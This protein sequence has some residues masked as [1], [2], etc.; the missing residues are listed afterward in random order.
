MFQWASRC[1]PGFSIIALLWL[2]FA[3]FADIGYFLPSQDQ[4][5]GRRPT[6]QPGRHSGDRPD[7][8]S[9]AQN[10]FIWFSVFVHLNAFY[11][12]LR[13]FFALVKTLRE[14]KKALQRRSQVKS[15]LSGDA[16][17]YLE[18]GSQPGL[19]LDVLDA[20]LTESKSFLSG[21]E[22]IHAIIVPN[23]KEDFD[24]LRTTLN[25]LASHPR[26]STQYEVSLTWIFEIERIEN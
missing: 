17:H 9:L 12:A 15:E 10:T 5:R 3:A 2:S 20:K 4:A 14:S 7:D 18:G 23:Y 16:E 24:T 19:S 11:F 21:E 1:V 25:V 6:T 13:L 22:V 26:A 8:L